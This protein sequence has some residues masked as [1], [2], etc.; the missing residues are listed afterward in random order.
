MAFK[1]IV[2]AWNADGIEP[3]ASLKN[4]GFEPGYKPPAAVFNWFWYGV[5]QCL[6]ELQNTAVQKTELASTD[7]NTISETGMYSYSVNCTNKPTAQS[8]A[9]IVQKHAANYVLQAAF[10]HGSGVL[11]TR[12]SSNAASSW[13]DW[14][15]FYTSG[16]LSVV[17][18]HG[19]IA[20]DT[21]LDTLQ[22]VGVYYADK[23]ATVATL[24]NCPTTKA[25]SL[26]VG[27]HAGVYQRLVEFDTAN[28]KV[29]FRN[30]YYE[31]G[32][33]EWHREF[34]T[35]NKPK[36]AEVDAHGLSERGTLIP[37]SSDLNTY[38][39]PG[40]YFVSGATDAATIQNS[41][42][43]G[44][45]FRL[46]VEAGYVPGYIR[47]YAIGVSGNIQTRYYQTSWTA[48]MKVITTADM[49]SNIFYHASGQLTNED[50]DTVLTTGF[51]YGAGSN[52]CAN[53]PAPA[54]S[55]FGLE[56]VQS[57]GSYYT[58]IAYVADAIWVRY[59]NSTTWQEWREVYTSNN[60]PTP[61]EIGAVTMKTAAVSL[62]VSG[63]S[64]NAQTVNVTGVT[65]NST[66]IVTAAPASYEHYNECG[67]RCSAQADG[68]LTFTCTDVPTS[69]VTANVL[70]LV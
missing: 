44:S 46:I 50:L 51:Y 30:Y 52:T 59:Y 47:Q 21:D 41:P 17:K 14:S 48:W 11:Y 61:A 20:T 5:S 2:P 69:A 39:T 18:D 63:W 26:E 28:P 7:L 54:G 49:E 38:K 29:Y 45:G 9:L 23:T 37:A 6:T 36:A 19:K 40:D 27:K 15:M 34:T 43:T 70:I 58:Q 55:G 53:S 62:P 33:G 31:N 12:Y 25:F 1:Q 35:A 42:M 66:I 60:K 24:S 64:S 4:S 8:G 57:A 67:V 65:A 13:T 56:V 3:P 10:I 16:N 68:N 22:E 32:W